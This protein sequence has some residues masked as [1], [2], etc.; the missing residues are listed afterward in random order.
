VNHKTMFASKRLSA[1]THVEV[2]YMG[3]KKIDLHQQIFV[4][5]LYLVVANC[6]MLCRKQDS[7]RK[8]V[9]CDLILHVQRPIKSPRDSQWIWT[10]KTTPGQPATRPASTDVLPDPPKSFGTDHSISQSR[11]FLLHHF[12]NHH[13]LTPPARLPIRISHP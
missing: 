8:Q 11:L 5:E 9:E 1:L 12:E 7:T 10:V 2:R 13:H 3:V 4:F 6:F